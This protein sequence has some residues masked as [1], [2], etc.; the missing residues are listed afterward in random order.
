MGNIRTDY[1]RFSNMLGTVSVHVGVRGFGTVFK[2]HQDLLIKESKYFNTILNK[3]TSDGIQSQKVTLSDE[4]APAT[5]E[6]FCQWLYRQPNA[7]S[8]IT[9]FESCIKAYMLSRHLEAPNFSSLCLDTLKSSVASEGVTSVDALMQKLER[10]RNTNEDSLRTILVYDLGRELAKKK[11]LVGTLGEAKA[12]APVD[13]S[14]HKNLNQS[15]VSDVNTTSAGEAPITKDPQVHVAHHDP[16]TTSTNSWFSNTNFNSNPTDFR[17]INTAKPASGGFGNCGNC[18]GGGVFDTSRNICA[19][20]GQT[21]NRLDLGDPDLV[22]SQPALKQASA[23][24]FP[25]GLTNT[26][27]F[28]QIGNSISSQ[29][30]SALFGSLASSKNTSTGFGESRGFETQTP[31][32]SSGGG[33]FGTASNNTQGPSGSG[34]G[35]LFGQSRGPS[36]FGNVSSNTQ[37]N[38]FGSTSLFGRP[39]Q[40]PSLFGNAPNNNQPST[41][42]STG[43][44]GRPNQGPSL[45]G[46]GNTNA[47]TH[48]NVLQY[49]PTSNNFNTNWRP[50]GPSVTPSTTTFWSDQPN[51][52]LTENYQTINAHPDFRNLSL[53]EMRYASYCRDASLKPQ[54]N[55]YD[56]H[57]QQSDLRSANTNNFPPPSTSGQFNQSCVAPAPLTSNR[58]PQSETSEAASKVVATST[59]QDIKTLK[60]LEEQQHDQA[61]TLKE[62]Q[63]QLKLLTTTL[64]KLVMDNEQRSQVVEEKQKE[65]DKIVSKNR[66]TGKALDGEGVVKPKDLAGISEEAEAEHAKLTVEEIELLSGTST[67]EVIFTP[68]TSRAQS[69]DSVVIVCPEDD[70]DEEGEEAV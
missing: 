16:K 55:H 10:I 31:P 54:N 34:S 8:T 48:N 9:S 65:K 28:P 36:L 25:H 42:G 57:S 21:P 24:G 19:T 67:T 61:Q 64:A 53:E 69:W 15:G 29:Q 51:T 13:I 41:F 58:N 22:P 33:L 30:V 27:C 26:S 37:G 63:A 43:L 59:H 3:A 32:Q 46:S 2:I 56:Q 40:Q 66:S 39:A 35:G 23:N 62:M 60:T 49:Q 17:L 7:I 50:F 6:I 12:A 45:F 52:W 5:F 38:T 68:A 47:Y 11:D 20:C 44:F 1:I 4:Y 18:K 14:A 70:S